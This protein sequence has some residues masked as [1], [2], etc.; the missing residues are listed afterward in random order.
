MN[1]RAAGAA[2]R[3]CGQ[4]GLPAAIAAVRFQSGEGGI[5]HKARASISNGMYYTVYYVLT[6]LRGAPLRTFG[7]TARGCFCDFE[8]LIVS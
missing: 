4:G 8:Q 1:L 3:F 6:A 2:L 5:F 7:F